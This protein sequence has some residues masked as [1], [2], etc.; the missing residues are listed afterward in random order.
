MLVPLSSRHMIPSST[1]EKLRSIVGRE[2]FFD[3]PEDKLAY[4]YD[5]TPLLKQ[6]PEAAIIPRSVEHI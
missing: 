1:V 3:S 6:L 4:S 2:N 5:G